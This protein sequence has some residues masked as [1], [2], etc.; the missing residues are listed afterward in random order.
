MSFTLVAHD[1]GE[2]AAIWCVNSMWI[3]FFAIYYII[4]NRL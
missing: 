2:A 3:A 1:S 4:K